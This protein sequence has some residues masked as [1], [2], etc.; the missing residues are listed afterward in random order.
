MR[1]HVEDRLGKV[2]A[3]GEQCAWQTVGCEPSLA[4]SEPLLVATS[5]EN[6]MTAA[7]V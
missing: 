7:G 1:P 6:T 3:R 2:L 5:W 4:V